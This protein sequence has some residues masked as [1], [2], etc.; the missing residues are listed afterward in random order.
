MT[1]ADVALLLGVMGG[2]FLWAAGFGF[3]GGDRRQD[4]A[5]VA[6]VGSLFVVVAAVLAVL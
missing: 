3:L 5:L 6:T 4:V 1:F 2:S